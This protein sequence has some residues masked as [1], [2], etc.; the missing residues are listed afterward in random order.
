LQELQLVS[1]QL[2]QADE[3]LELVDVELFPET[4]PNADIKRSTCLLLHSGHVTFSVSFW[5]KQSS[6]KVISHLLHLNS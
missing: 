1:L 2:L 3:E 4:K 6:S 5:L